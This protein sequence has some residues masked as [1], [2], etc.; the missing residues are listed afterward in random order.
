MFK[1]CIRNS[2]TNGFLNES[3]NWSKNVFS[4][5]VKFFDT[6]DNAKKAFPNGVV[7]D[8]TRIFVG[9]TDGYQ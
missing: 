6:E 8:V 3:G 4:W 9:E 7:C 1:Y 2:K 5:D